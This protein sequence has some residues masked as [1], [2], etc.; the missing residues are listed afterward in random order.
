MWTRVVVWAGSTLVLLTLAAC[1]SPTSAADRRTSVTTTSTPTTLAPP[2]T[3]TAPAAPPPCDGAAIAAV[4]GRYNRY[5]AVTSFGCSGAFAYALVTI[6]GPPPFTGGKGTL[7]LA[8][9]G[10]GWQIVNRTTYCADGSVPPAIS[11]SACQGS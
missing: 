3:T 5:A 6:T 4:V 7:L 8:G 10:G 11:Q 9:S 2:S 1:G